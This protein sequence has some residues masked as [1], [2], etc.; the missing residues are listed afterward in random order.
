MRQLSGSVLYLPVSHLFPSFLHETGRYFVSLRSWMDNLLSHKVLLAA[1]C[2]STTTRRDVLCD[3]VHSSSQNWPLQICVLDLQQVLQR[4]WNLIYLLTLVC[5]TVWHRE[6]RGSDWAM[7]YCKLADSHSCV[8]AV[9]LLTGWCDC[10][11]S[12]ICV[13][14]PSDIVTRHLLIKPSLA[15]GNH[16]K[17]AQWIYSTAFNGLKKL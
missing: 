11:F 16:L 13:H 15:T 7:Y 14:S 8:L 5:T 12:S 10:C 2:S 9:N 1:N 6:K 3:D 17:G 4:G